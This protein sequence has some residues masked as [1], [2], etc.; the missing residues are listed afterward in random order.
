M[1]SP[2]ED[3]A[4]RI[5]AFKNIDIYPV[6]SSEFTA[7]RDVISVLQAIAEGGAKIVQ[8]REKNRNKADIYQQALEY[9]RITS[10]YNMLLIINDHVDI[11]LAVEADGVHLGQDD[12]PISAARPVAPELLL[13]CSSHNIKEAADAQA[14]GADYVNV[15]P[16]YP[17]GTKAVPC[18]VVGIEMLESVKPHINIPFTVMGGIKEHHLGELFAAG[19]TRIAMVT[20]ITQA[21]DIAAKV[22]A[23][24]SHWN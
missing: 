9:R 8:L 13:G 5:A 2:F 17:T 6:V 10:Q 11:A 24:R 12:L 4:A 15:G 1:S 23:L 19:A 20:E 18:G 21:D 16:I 14:A 22:K 7:G 3:K